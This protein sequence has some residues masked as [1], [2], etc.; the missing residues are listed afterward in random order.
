M[1]HLLKEKKLKSD[2]E[3]L[4]GDDPVD[5]AM[6]EALQMSFVRDYQTNEFKE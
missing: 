1:I 5:M 2:K 4:W 3:L 6:S